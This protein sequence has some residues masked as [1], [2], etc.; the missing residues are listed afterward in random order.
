MSGWDHLD[1]RGGLSVLGLVSPTL[2]TTEPLDL[3]IMP[4][5]VH[6]TGPGIRE[7]SG[8]KREQS[9]TSTALTERT[10]QRSSLFFS[11]HRSTIKSKKQLDREGFSA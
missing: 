11:S 9:I 5:S 3:L 8:Q 7:V 2:G 4:L 10:K 6:F 1:P